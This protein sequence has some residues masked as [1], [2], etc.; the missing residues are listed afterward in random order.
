MNFDASSAFPQMFRFLSNCFKQV[1]QWLDSIIL[2][3]NFSI[4]D[5]SIAIIVFGLVFTVL[6]STVRNF[7]FQ[8][9]STVHSSR[10]E[11][12]RDKKN[13]DRYQR[14]RSDRRGG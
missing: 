10:E 8:S 2:F 1:I 14:R 3:N 13:K 7:A 12:R 4:L 5:F 6:L 11:A 9:E